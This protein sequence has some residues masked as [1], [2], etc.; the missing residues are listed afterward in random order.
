MGKLLI[1][2][3]GFSFPE[4]A[5]CFYP[6][7]LPRS[8]WLAYYATQFNS[9]EINSTFYHVPMAK[10]VARWEEL[11]QHVTFSFKAH[12]NITHIHDLL[13]Q[14]EATEKFLKSIEVFG[15][16]P[17]RH[18]VL[19]QLPQSIEKKSNFLSMIFE[20]FPRTFLY[21]FEFRHE[22]WF[23][24]E[25]YMILKK[26]NATIVLSDSPRKKD[27]TYLWPYH[28]IQTA[29]FSYIRFHGKEKLYGSEYPQQDMQQYAQLIQQKLKNGVAVYCY[30]NNGFAYG[31]KNAERNA[32]DIISCC[33]LTKFTCQFY[34]YF[35]S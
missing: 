19:F 34:K 29:N 7:D 12:K 25:V 3:S 1:G 16:T 4:A 21:A 6:I 17:A 24:E 10:T 11:S 14:S 8:E 28:D 5:Y 35:L 2:T 23:C 30:F 31:V 22:S 26:Y 27:N 20:K 13:L 9:I 18:T 33:V 32:T 15:Q